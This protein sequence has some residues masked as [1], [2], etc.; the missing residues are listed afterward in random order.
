[1][2]EALFFLRAASDR[3]LPV[4]DSYAAA[5]GMGNIPCADHVCVAVND[6][7]EIVGFIRL[8][9]DDA[10]VCH[11]NP[12]VVYP[13]WRGVGLGRALID[14]AAQRFGEVRLVSRGSSL[15]F[16]EALGFT[17]LPWDEIKPEIVEE[18]TE[19][20]LRD[21]CHPVPLSRGAKERES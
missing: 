16:Y 7:D 3:D 9:F 6:S 4:L 21:E 14:Y 15:A 2:S 20:E 11:V 10:K 1:M 19:C 17:P 5:E 8:V 18:C 12:V 13:S